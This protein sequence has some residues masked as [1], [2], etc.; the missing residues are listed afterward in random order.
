MG[1]VGRWTPPGER[2]LWSSRPHPLFILLWRAGAIIGLLA[3][4]GVVAWALSAVGGGG[5]SAT[6]EWWRGAVVLGLVA[7]AA[8]VLAWSAL[9]WSHHEFVLTEERAI[10]ASGVISRFVV[11]I[12]LD[13]VQ[14]IAAYR[15]LRERIFGL[16]TVGLAS[17]GTDTFE[18]VWPMVSR[19]AAVVQAVTDAVKVAQRRRTMDAKPGEAAG[20][21][22][23]AR[24]APVIGL[25]G[26]IGAGKSEVGR[27]MAA[28]GCLV[29][30]SDREARAMLD[31]PDVRDELVRWWG[32]AILAPDGRV[33]RAA[34]ADIVFKDQEQRRR[35]EAL[36]HP[37]LKAARREII[38]RAQRG[39]SADGPPPRAIV[40]DAPLLFEAGVDRECDTVVFVDA[41]REARLARVAARGWD[42][43]ELARR[44]SAQL[45][46]EQKRAR[47]AH[48][49]M[50]TGSIADLEMQV[51]G[52]LR[53]IEA[54]GL[55]T[56]AS[57][58][59]DPGL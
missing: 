42:E 13:R 59:P 36:V 4:A 58:E 44:E 28:K 17:A 8:G 50:N 51:E 33:N 34:V 18:V 25:A 3:L 45:P 47:S 20:E 54:G 7:A 15:S 27:I 32:E 41:P 40:I 21:G 23:A 29:I 57:G 52:V 1:D 55:P 14:N 49:V 19:P 11:Q 46:L 12:P 9:V 16:G 53:R 35:L 2:V 22:R 24:R 39:E 31:R 56:G 30:D 43:A 10:W 38:D 6:L 48:V 26:G 5:H 37:L